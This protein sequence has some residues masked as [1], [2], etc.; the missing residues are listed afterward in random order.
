VLKLRI[1]SP[2]PLPLR[3]IRTSRRPS[4]SSISRTRSRSVTGPV[5]A[6]AQDTSVVGDAAHRGA[7]HEPVAGQY[8][9]R[10]GGRAEEHSAPVSTLKNSSSHNA[11]NGMPG[12]EAG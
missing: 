8:V 12:G 6:L 9:G 11:A 4:S 5:S 7:E 2:H 3:M 1:T 10:Q